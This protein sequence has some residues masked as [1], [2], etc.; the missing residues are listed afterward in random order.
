MFFCVPYFAPN[1]YFK[2]MTID[3]RRLF[4][5]SAFILTS[6]FII[7]IISI[8]A[9]AF[10]RVPLLIAH[11]GFFSLAYILCSKR[12]GVN[13]A[14]N[15]IFALIFYVLIQ[16]LY[17]GEEWMVIVQSIAIPM[18][19]SPEFPRRVYLSPISVPPVIL[20]FWTLFILNT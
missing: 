16:N 13:F 4:G 11:I 5:I 17:L 18:P 14:Q 12:V 1:L 20:T 2:K 15:F 7:L 6:I 8:P 3:L 10:L 19:H 9:F